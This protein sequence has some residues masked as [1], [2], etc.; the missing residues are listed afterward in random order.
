MKKMIAAMVL[1]ALGM[2]SAHA[3]DLAIVSGFETYHFHNNA[4]LNDNNYGLG[5]VY[6]G[7]VAGYYY[8]SY[9]QNSFYAGH[10]WFY[11][12]NSHLALGCEAALITGYDNHTLSKWEGTNHPISPTF[13]P[14]IALTQGKFTAVI[15]VAPPISGETNGNV[16][17]QFRYKV[18]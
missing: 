7:W 16:S 13:A 10:E 4:K 14:E 15:V 1:V 17:V 8:N 3:A 2:G 18:K 11:H 12:V 5:L 9:R 6:D